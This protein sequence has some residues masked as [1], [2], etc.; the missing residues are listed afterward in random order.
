LKWRSRSLKGSAVWTIWIVKT[1]KRVL[2]MQKMAEAGKQKSVE[3][4]RE[5][6]TERVDDMEVE[7]GEYASKGTACEGGLG[8]EEDFREM[9]RRLAHEKVAARGGGQGVRGSV[10]GT[11]ESSG[12]RREVQGERNEEVGAVPLPGEERYDDSGWAIARLKRGDESGCVGVKAGGG[13]RC[14][15]TTF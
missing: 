3:T 15:V 8:N 11:G 13:E 6:R 7:G 4:G 12:Q 10:G 2:D 14:S 5:R 1:G 9:V